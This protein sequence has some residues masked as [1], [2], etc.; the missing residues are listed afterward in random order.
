MRLLIYFLSIKTPFKEEDK[1]RSLDYLKPFI[2]V[3][4]AL[5]EGADSYYV[6]NLIAGKITETLDLKGCF[7]KM[8][9]S[10]GDRIELVA[11]CGLTEKFLFS[12]SYDGSDCVCSGMPG[13]TM[14]FP[15]LQSVDITGEKELFIAEGIQA[16]AVAPI[17]A[18]Q[19]IIAMLALFAGA[20]REFMDAELDFAN[21]LAGQGVLSIV[22]KRR[23]DALVER[24][25]QY[26]RIFQE[27]SSTI[28][29]T[30]NIEKVL[31]LVV[32]KI[33]EA[34]GVKGCIVRLLDPKTQNLYVARSYGLSREFLD[35]GP[36]DAQKSIAENMAG[37]IVVI[38][39][40]F[41]DP[42]IQYPAEHAKEGVHKL[43]SVPLIVRGKF[44]GVLRILTGE[45]PPFNRREIN[46]ATAIAQQ[47]AFAIENARIYQRLQCEYE[48]LLIDFGYKG[49]SH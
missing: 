38:D 2:E 9:T 37:Q 41:T 18:G 40:V 46:L 19:E 42:R 44:L 10:Q 30:L 22:G 1:M 7:I 36:V 43:L 32:S 25:R 26:L 27:I 49:S 21:T 13:K 15:Q 48:Q 29:E 16:F 6:M 28:S 34:M 4:R 3:G 12:E 5:G 24:E 20:P 33:T 47:C 8:K 11:S 45:R 39:D 35:K 17:K 23:V 14:C 31:E